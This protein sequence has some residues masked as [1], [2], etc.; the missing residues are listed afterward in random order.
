MG[1]VNIVCDSLQ[2]CWFDFMCDICDEKLWY[3]R[4]GLCVENSFSK[5]LR[6]RIREL[7]HKWWLYLVI[8]RRRVCSWYPC[9]MQISRRQSDIYVIFNCV[10]L[11]GAGSFANLRNFRH[12]VR[13][14]FYVMFLNFPLTNAGRV[15][16]T[17][18]GTSKFF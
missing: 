5:S 8:I 2:Y 17:V 18:F 7:S 13:M 10:I 11:R 6:G 15:F 9:F 16:R 14:F 12:E 3:K 1:S 4:R